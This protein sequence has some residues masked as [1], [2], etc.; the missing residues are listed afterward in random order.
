MKKVNKDR[1]YLAHN[2]LKLREQ[3]NL[4]QMDLAFLAKTT[5]KCISDLELAKRNVKIDTISKIAEALDV[6]LSEITKAN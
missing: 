5:N 1:I 4:T 2:I 3:K 6:S